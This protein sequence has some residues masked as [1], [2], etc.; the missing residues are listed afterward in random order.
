MKIL[1]FCS[2]QGNKPEAHGVGYFA[3]TCA[4]RVDAGKKV[5]DLPGFPRLV[6]G[7]IST[8]LA[9]RKRWLVGMIGVVEYLL[10]TLGLGFGSQSRHGR[11]R[12]SSVG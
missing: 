11:S 12:I 4:T 6:L 9:T 2:L 1:Y 8:N 5:N 10:K 7:E 3:Y